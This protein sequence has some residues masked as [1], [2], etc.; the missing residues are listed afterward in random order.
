MTEE[1]RPVVGFEGLYEVSSEGRVRSLDRN[2]RGRHGMRRISGVLLRPGIASNDYP[3]VAIGRGNTR[4]VHS[5]VAAAF[6]GPCPI[7]QEVRHRDGNRRNPRADNLRY[8]T[9]GQNIADAILSG[10]W[11]SLRRKR[12]L[13]KFPYA[14]FGGA[15]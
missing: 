14:R 6:I 15:R 1:W 5:L 10:A 7:G 8:G 4:T 13:V 3:T 2:V 11:F 12:W 9:R